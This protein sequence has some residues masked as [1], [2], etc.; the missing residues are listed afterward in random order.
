MS[1]TQFGF[2]IWRYTGYLGFFVF[3]YVVYALAFS[4]AAHL[5]KKYLHRGLPFYPALLA[6]IL[7]GFLTISIPFPLDSPA[8]RNNMY[9][10]FTITAISWLI[11]IVQYKL[12]ANARPAA[13][14]GGIC[15]F[16]AV[17]CPGCAGRVVFGAEIRCGSIFGECGS[18][19]ILCVY[20]TEHGTAVELDLCS[21]WDLYNYRVAAD[22]P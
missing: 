7:T 18:I 13:K 10:F 19:G 21:C 4:M 9:H 2:S 1:S 12:H 15:G 5:L 6:G 20:G 11:C 8:S 16:P 22:M 3:R 17:G 14:K